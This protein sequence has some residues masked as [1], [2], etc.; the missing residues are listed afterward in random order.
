[1]R[2]VITVAFSTFRE[3]RFKW[4]IELLRSLDTQS[5]ND[6]KIVV[7]VDKNKQYYERLA[8]AVEKETAIKCRT[9]V[10]F[11]PVDKGIAHS[12]NIA[13]SH[14]ETPYIAYTD[15]DAIPDHLWLEKLLRTL[16]LN[17]KVV[18]ATG[19]VLCKWE[20]GTENY[21]SWF[22]KE[23][24]W[25][26][27]C[28]PWHIADIAEVRNGFASNLGFKREVLLECGGFSEKFG[29]NPL[30]PISGEEPEIGIRLAKSGYITLWNPDV[31]VYHRVS[32]E[33]L[34]I[35]SI[36]ARC[37]LEGKTKAYLHRI[38]GR[39]A[40]NFEADYLQT[41]FKSSV[42]TRSFRSKAVILLTIAMVFSG[43]LIYS[44]KS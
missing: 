1:M 32:E 35:R 11:N 7:V 8:D 27:G 29:Y 12:R 21:S 19:P 17:K 3:A 37:F 28:T 25:I 22:P 41:L 31:V 13:L 23:L 44:F 33:R 15:D 38:Y 39:K 2:D 42:E 4:V 40:I 6:F 5:M 18:A 10:I 43:Y 14:S 36:L 34:K 20:T 30:N 26:V 16:K 24:Y 9:N